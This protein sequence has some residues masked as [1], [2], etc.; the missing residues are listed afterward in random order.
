[1]GL[2]GEVIHRLFPLSL[3]E[4]NLVSHT[5]NLY[6]Q[7]FLDLGFLGFIGWLAT[8]MLGLFMSWKVYRAGLE[9][10]RGGWIAGIGVGL[11]C[12]Q[13]AL[14]FHGFSDAVTW[15]MVRGAPLVWAL[16]GLAM[17]MGNVRHYQNKLDIV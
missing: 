3:A 14:A 8:L 12:S 16:W 6:F 9:T 7:V 4:T 17:S 15:G 11:F 2:A 10:R 5:H 1:M 13:L